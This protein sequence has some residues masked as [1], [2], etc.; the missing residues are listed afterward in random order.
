[1]STEPDGSPIRKPHDMMD[2]HLLDGE[3]GPP[4]IASVGDGTVR[5]T[6]RVILRIEG[7]VILGL[8]V[9]GYVRYGG[10]WWVFALLLFVSGIGAL[11]Y[12]PGAPFCAFTYDALPTY[13]G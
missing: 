13:I 10:P 1:M 12:L 5:S 11:G 8:A 6:P 9:F 7:A 3:S 4:G 2:Q